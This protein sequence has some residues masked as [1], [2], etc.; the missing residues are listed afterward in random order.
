MAWSW[1]EAGGFKCPPLS[2]A[3]S[4]PQHP[5]PIFFTGN[6]QRT[7][8]KGECV[9]SVRSLRASTEEWSAWQQAADRAGL[10]LNAWAR[11]ALARVSEL[12]NALARQA[13]TDESTD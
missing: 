10:S 9:T 12:E 11:K 7:A 5:S 8:F 13:S 1:A 3:L 4:S 2:G 6:S